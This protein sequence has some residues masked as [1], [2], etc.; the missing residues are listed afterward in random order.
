[1]N[2]T[3]KSTL[4]IA[5]ILCIGLVALFALLAFRPTPPKTERPKVIP[6][7]TTTSP[8]TRSGS[9]SIS[10]NGT[11]RATR[12]INLVA[13]I[14]GRV[15][16]IA[17]SAVSGGF[18]RRGATLFELDPSDYANAVSIAEAEVTQRQYELLLAQEE[19]DIARDEWRRLQKQRGSAAVPEST[20]LGVLVFKEPQLRL[21]ES[22]LKSAEARLEDAQTR[23]NRTRI[24]APFNGRIRTKN[25]DIGQYVTPGQAVAS[26]YNTD[27]VEIPVPLQSEEAA[28]IDNLWQR[29]SSQNIS[30]PATIRT[31]FGGQTYEW[32]GYVDR[33]EGTLDANTRTINVVVRVDQPYQSNDEGRPPLLVG[34][35]SE[36]E[37]Q[38][39]AFDNFYIIPRAALKENNTVWIF[40]NGRLNVREV[41]IIQETEGMV[42]VEDGINP[43]ER[44]ITSKMDVFSDGMEVRTVE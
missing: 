10:G 17:P 33:T 13:E 27:R 5:G 8:E 37:I 22:L 18:F 36:V 19:V 20:A 38:G 41:S 9:I 29:E 30:I 16:N 12:E 26:I 35:F 11:V 42:F 4:T 44:L 14:S 25:V 43:G 23:L 40:N 34:M 3:L 6:L 24:S 15:V 28:L 1:M 7:V 39:Q 31:A 32:Q 21:A 2:K